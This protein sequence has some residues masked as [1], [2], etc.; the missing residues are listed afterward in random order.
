MAMERLNSYCA[1]NTSR[2]LCLSRFPCCVY[3]EHAAANASCLV[4]DNLPPLAN[5]GDRCVEYPWRVS[6][7]VACF[8]TIATILVPV[9]LGYLTC[10]LVERRAYRRVSKRHMAKP[11]SN[12]FAAASTSTIPAGQI[13]KVDSPASVTS[14]ELLGV[15]VSKVVRDLDAGVP[16]SEVLRELFSGFTYLEPCDAAGRLAIISYRV[17]TVADDSF[18]LGAEA[19]LCAVAAARDND[20]TYLWLDAWAYREQPPWATYVHRN[21]L[22][23]LAQVMTRVSLVVWLPR[24][25][26]HAH[27]EYQHRIWLRREL[28]KVKP[29]EAI[30]RSEFQHARLRAVG[31]TANGPWR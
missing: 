29:Q 11:G 24:A 26:A 14:T 12:F 16:A 1:A 21:F 31:Q 9:L 23:T 30:K 6:P 17:V 19:F 27:G 22:R 3:E 28:H 5:G 7:L 10:W 18:T 4:N 2:T 25:R 20:V 8:A 15:R 13:E